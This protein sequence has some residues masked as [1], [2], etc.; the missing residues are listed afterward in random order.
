MKKEL[1]GV[2]RLKRRLPAL[3][4][5]GLSALAVTSVRAQTFASSVTD[6][7]NLVGNGGQVRPALADLDHD[8]DLDLVTG[9]NAGGN[10]A[11]FV[12]YENTGTHTAP[13][14]GDPVPDVFVLPY[15]GGLLTPVFVDIDD[16]GDLDLF[17]GVQAGETWFIEN[18]GTVT[19]PVFSTAV[20]GAFGI[21]DI[22]Y[23]SS[24][25]FTDLDNDGDQDVLIGEYYGGLYYFQNSGDAMNP[26]FS[27]AQTLPFGLTIS[28]NYQRPNFVDLD[29]DGDQDLLSGTE[30][31]DMAYYQNTGTVS[32]PAYAPFVTNPFGLSNVG[33]SSCAPALAD[34]DFDGD[35]D[36]LAGGNNNVFQF[37][38]NTTPLPQP[39]VPVDG[40]PSG[41]LLTCYQSTAD[42]YATGTAIGQLGWYDAPTGGNYLGGGAQFTT[43]PL[44]GATT[45]YVQDST[46]GGASPSRL[47]LTVNTS[48]PLTDQSV[49]ST[50]GT[51]CIS[52]IPVIM[53]GSSETSVN[54]YLRNSFDNSIISGPLAG[55]GGALTFT[56]AAITA[57]TTYNV[58]AADTLY[59]SGGWSICPTTMSQT[60]TVT[61]AQPVTHTV[62]ADVC[63]ASDYT[64]A[65]GTVS[66]A[67]TADESHVSTLSGQAANGCDSIVTETLVSLPQLVG[68]VTNT[69]CAEES[70]VINGT[71]Y[72]AA[73][74]SG[75]EVLTALNGCD[76]TVTIALNV[77]PALASS[78]TTTICAEVIIVVNGT[79]YGASNPS[80]T[81]VFTGVNGCDS[82][83]TIALNV[84]APIDA[85]VIVAGTTLT[86]NQTGATYLWY[87]CNAGSDIS[88]A[89]S[90]SFT[91]PANGWYGVNLTLN[92]CSIFSGCMEVTTVG[93]EELSAVSLALYP[94]PAGTT[95]GISGLEQLSG[96]REIAIVDNS[97][98][99]VQ[100]LDPAAASWDVSTLQTGMYYVKI[101]HGNGIETIRF[102]KK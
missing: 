40:T 27:A 79:V 4:L 2:N 68:S 83:V 77:L 89:T 78:I 21:Y 16:D 82:I 50:I 69:I 73:N 93:L 87:D 14:Y 5:T 28:G 66:T 88:G 98:K 12:Y 17:T 41:N 96:I 86:V 102:V 59:T 92:N 72:N 75:T 99:R 34:L 7:F 48:L 3:L 62:S 63:Y 64:Y 30:S 90:Q 11:M 35:F 47:A 38:L 53:T 33:T 15:V 76:S 6:P 81:E 67:I 25:T 20:N 61:I 19:S 51:G 57:T 95:F 71:T 43:P 32:A 85:T 29:G 80:G 49:S 18:T 37:F 31:G 1:P 13:Q 45:F 23:L 42:L 84:S 8:G 9:T 24:A 70:V 54:Y 10:G 26:A 97:G 65:D 58:L 91:A 94:N 74:P 101:A 44:A 60:V 52:A 39:P 100:V 55:T 22:G 46:G 36:V 56:A